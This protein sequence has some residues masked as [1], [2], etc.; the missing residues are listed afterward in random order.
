MNHFTMFHNIED[1]KFIKMY[2]LSVVA[3]G[4]C[5]I[6]LNMNIDGSVR[7]DGMAALTVMATAVA[8]SS[9]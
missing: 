5:Y 3:L 7:T 2:T 9:I 6:P 4:W 1:C 8:E